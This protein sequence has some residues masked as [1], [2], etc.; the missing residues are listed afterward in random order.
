MISGKIVIF[1]FCHNRSDVTPS[2]LDG[3]R[4]IV[5][6][7][8]LNCGG[9]V[10]TYDDTM[11][12]S[13]PGHPCVLLDRNILCSCDIVAEGDFLMESLA[14]CGEHEGPD[15][16]VCFTVGL[17]FVDC[18]EALDGTVGTPI[19]RNLTSVKQPLLVSLESF[20]L[21]SKLMH[22]PVVLRDF[23]D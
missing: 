7:N 20:W 21:S 13:V 1:C 15:L 2:V 9:I 12:V 17:A 22:A 23:I 6:P 19:G 4:Q 3:G 10:C 5:L 8:W 16:E 14:T 11:L 18:L